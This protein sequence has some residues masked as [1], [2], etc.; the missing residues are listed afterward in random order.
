MR[1]RSGSGRERIGRK[2]AGKLRS[3]VEGINMALLAFYGGLMVGVLTGM[4]ITALFF[5]IRTE[6]SAQ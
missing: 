5:M 1:P 2:S 6:E 4:V 3:S